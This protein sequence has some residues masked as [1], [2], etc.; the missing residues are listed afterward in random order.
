MTIDDSAVNDNPNPFFAIAEKVFL[1]L[2]TFEM[3]MKIVGMGFIF[4]KDSYLRDSWNILDFLIVITSWP[5]EFQNS[6]VELIDD[7]QYHNEQE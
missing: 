6:D 4:G 7:L 3:N 5:T 1:Y 2:Y